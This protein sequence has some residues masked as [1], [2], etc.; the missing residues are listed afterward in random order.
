M[1]GMTKKQGD[2]IIKLLEGILGN[3][4][5]S[6]YE[7]KSSFTEE[8]LPINQG[9]AMAVIRGNLQAIGERLDNTKTILHDVKGD[10]SEITGIARRF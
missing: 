8:N 10:I 6:S 5:G 9:M 1:E 3:L 4:D 2:Q 7:G